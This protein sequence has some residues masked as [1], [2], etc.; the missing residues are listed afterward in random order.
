MAAADLLDIMKVM[1]RSFLEEHPLRAG[2][3]NR[4]AGDPD[5]TS[6]R[7]NWLRCVL[8]GLTVLVGGA[9]NAWAQGFGPDPFRPYN[10]M[11]DP[12]VFGTAPA[13]WGGPNAAAAAR[14]QPQPI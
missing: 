12:Y 4:F 9:T 10:S 1:A 5:M 3:V 2:M 8:G 6:T 13:G 14:G 11:Y 7:G